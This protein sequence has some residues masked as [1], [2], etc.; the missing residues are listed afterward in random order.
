MRKKEER[1]RGVEPEEGRKRGLRKK[2]KM[3]CRGRIKGRKR[4]IGIKK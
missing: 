1:I 2:M 3:G 4:E